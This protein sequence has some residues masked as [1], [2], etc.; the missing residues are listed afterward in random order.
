MPLHPDF[1]DLLAV[2]AAHKL[3]GAIRAAACLD[4]RGRVRRGCD[5]DLDGESHPANLKSY[6]MHGPRLENRR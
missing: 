2:F 3:T 5:D 1:R 4:D 6:P